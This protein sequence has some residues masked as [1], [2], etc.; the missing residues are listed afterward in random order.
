MCVCIDSLANREYKSWL[1]WK[2]EII[3][4]PDGDIHATVWGRRAALESVQRP[5]SPSAYCNDGPLKGNRNFLPVLQDSRIL[6]FSTMQLKTYSF[7]F[8]CNSYIYSFILKKTLILKKQSYLCPKKGTRFKQSSTPIFFHILI[9]FKIRIIN[10]SLV[11]SKINRNTS[12]IRTDS[13]SPT[14]P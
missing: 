10:L 4:G 12:V 6:Y 5:A 9:N 11:S 7:F 8:S 13:Q 3:R 1:T 2:S 14:I